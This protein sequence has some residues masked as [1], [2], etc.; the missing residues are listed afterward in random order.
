MVYKSTT[1][2]SGSVWV[3][4]EAWHEM[5][6]ETWSGMNGERLLLRGEFDLARKFYDFFSNCKSSDANLL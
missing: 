1:S 3:G 2:N 5:N 6:L 4:V